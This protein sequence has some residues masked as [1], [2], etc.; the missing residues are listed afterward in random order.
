MRIWPRREQRTIP[1]G[2]AVADNTP[3]WRSFQPR[4]PT[5]SLAIADVFACVRVLAGAAASLPLVPYRRTATGRVRLTSGMLY[6]LLQNPAPATTQANL[7][8]T[9]M[10]HLLLHGNSYVGKFRGSDGRVE[11]LGCLDPANVTVELVAGSPRYTVTDPKTGRQS[12]HG[13][14]DITHVRAL[15]TD[16]LVGLSPL[17]ECRL[18]VSYAQGMGEFAEAFTRNGMRPSGILSVPGGTTQGSVDQTLRALSERHEGS[19]NAHRIALVK[20]E[21]TYTAMTGPLDDLQFAEQ[22]RLSTAEIC[23]LFGVPPWMVGASTGDSLTYSNAEQQQLL[24]VTHALRPWLVLV[25]RAISAD[26]DLC[27]QNVYV[28]FLL[29]ALLRADSATRAD[30]YTKALNPA[31]GW[32]TRAE[33]RQLENLEPEATPPT[34]AAQPQTNGAVAV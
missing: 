1:S 2:G 17:K 25:E 8:G 7:V 11:Q 19:R 9:A 33:I 5:E 26:T 34:P 12:I 32:M 13:T 14:A 3:S 27:S 30:V 23:R 31:T 20:G 15:S 28:E 16:G 22:R 24:F 29:D 4:S 21:V 18:A 6:G 10:A